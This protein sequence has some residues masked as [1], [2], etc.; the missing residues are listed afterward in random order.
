MVGKWGEGDACDMPIDFRA[1]GTMDGPVEKWELNGDML[2]MVGIPSS[3]RLKVV[4]AN[5]MESRADDGKAD[6]RTLKRC[7]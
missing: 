5:T 2:T 6:P 3:I 1:D 4:D 7:K